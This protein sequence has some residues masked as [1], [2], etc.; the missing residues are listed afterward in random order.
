MY[1][2]SIIKQKSSFELLLIYFLKT[3]INFIN[4]YD[5]LIFI[6]VTIFYKFDL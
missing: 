1:K 2:K 5:I 4:F 6:Y 3:M